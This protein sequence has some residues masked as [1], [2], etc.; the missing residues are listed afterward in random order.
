[1]IKSLAQRPFL[2]CFIQIIGVA[3]AYFIA[4][5]LGNLFVIPPSY[6]TVIFPSSGIALASVL[7][8]GKRAGWGILLGAVLLNGT[9][10]IT[11]NDLSESLN[12]SLIALAISGGAVLQAFVGAYLVRRLA[13]KPNILSNKKNILLFLFYGGFVSALLNSTFSVSLLVAMGRMP[14]EA[15][16]LN[17]L[18][19]WGGDALGIV[20]FA[21]L[22]L[23]CLSTENP[24]WQCRRWMMTLPISI[25]FLLTVTA[26][27][28][29]IE[30]SNARVK[31]EFDYSAKELSSVMETAVVSNLNTLESLNSFYLSS[32]FVD[33]NEF[34]TFVSYSLK[35]FPGIES[36]IISRLFDPFF[37]T[38]S[39]GE[40]TG[41][42]LSVVSGIVHQSGGHLLV[43]SNQSES[44]HGSTFKLLFPILG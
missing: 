7:L 29:E 43:E 12:P 31:M 23:I 8:Y 15:F 13:G 16:F 17:W 25:I 19:W 30:S 38:K 21:P 6:A 39:Q 10:P 41:L 26:V 11:E 42:G 33:K 1:M 20:I 2:I 32:K 37:T 22:T 27:F 3:A 24:V 28:Y 4:G 14:A 44:N 18:S 9:I 40:G 34:K 5:K 36:K 35:N